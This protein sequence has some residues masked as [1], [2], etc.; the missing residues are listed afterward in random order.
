M[1]IVINRKNIMKLQNSM[2]QNDPSSIKNKMSE[3]NT[4]E[5]SNDRKKYNLSPSEFQS[6]QEMILLE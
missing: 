2:Y 1:N 5:A 3:L 4:R 6:E